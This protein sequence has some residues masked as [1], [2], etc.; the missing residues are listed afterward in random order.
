MTR[1]RWCGEAGAQ[2]LDV[3]GLTPGGGVLACYEPISSVAVGG[4]RCRQNQAQQTRCQVR[5]CRS[6]SMS[7]SLAAASGCV[8]IKAA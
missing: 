5:R 6:T 8:S 4:W 1:I 3:G 7:R 2:W